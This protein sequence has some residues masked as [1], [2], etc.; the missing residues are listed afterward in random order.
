MRCPKSFKRVSNMMSLG[1]PKGCMKESQGSKVGPKGVQRGSKDCATGPPRLSKECP[2]GVQRVPSG[3]PKGVR[4]FPWV[5]KKFP[6]CFQR[7]S[8]KVRRPRRSAP[9][10]KISMPSHEGGPPV[11]RDPDKVLSEAQ[12]RV[13]KLEVAWVRPVDQRIVWT[14]EFIAWAQ[15]RRTVAKAQELRHEEA[16]L[17]DGK[18]RFGLAEFHSVVQSFQ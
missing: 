10:K 7:V 11:S 12:S 14:Q 1:G 16:L 15:K 3:C 6:V 4:W 13:V 17:R 8:E 18:A 2:Q 9:L 5:S